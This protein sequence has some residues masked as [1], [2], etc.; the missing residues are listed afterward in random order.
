MA[1]SRT[2]HLPFSSA[3]CQAKQLHDFPHRGPSIAA[4]WPNTP[5]P[6]ACATGWSSGPLFSKG[7]F[8]LVERRLGGQ[9]HFFYAMAGLGQDEQTRGEEGQLWV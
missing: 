2:R 7:L 5:A 4:K 6:L 9:T 3:H 8:A 1:L